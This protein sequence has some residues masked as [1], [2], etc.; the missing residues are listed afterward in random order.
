MV[1]ITVRGA[2]ILGLSIAWVCVLRGAQVRVIDPNGPAA[3]SSGGVVGALAPHVPENWN[4]KKAFQLRSLLAA[5][6]FWSGVAEAGGQ[7]PG[8]RRSGRLQTVADEHALA[9][10]QSRSRSA[11]TLWGQHARWIVEPA[12]DTPWSPHSPTGQVIRDTLSALVHPR[13]ACMALVSALAARGVMTQ[14]DGPDAGQVVWATGVQGLDA[15][16]REHHRPVGNGVKGQA[17]VLDYDAAGAPQLFVDG[18]HIIPHLDGTVAIGSTSEREFADPY[19]TDEQLDAVIA[20][21]RAAVPALVDAPVLARWAGVRPRARSR[22]PMLG[23]WPGRPG[24]F[25][26]NGGFK[27]GFGMAPAIAHVMADL[28]L[29]GTDNIPEGFE[30]TA[31]F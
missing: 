20:K 18:V 28:M 22:A 16:S 30:V 21:A 12:P 13:Q 31:S 14:T 26:A 15:L 24:H 5:E 7:A 19:T 17:A 4:P 9:L 10:A 1:E 27:I 29:E 25:I 6:E 11:Q 3:G 23:P 8:Y 2:G